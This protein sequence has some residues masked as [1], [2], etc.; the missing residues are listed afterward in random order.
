MNKMQYARN[1]L[2][3]FWDAYFENILIQLLYPMF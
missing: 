2:L 3:V 1:L